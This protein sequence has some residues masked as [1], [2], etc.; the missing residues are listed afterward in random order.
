MR[1]LVE[2][3]LLLLRIMF[4]RGQRPPGVDNTLSQLRFEIEAADLDRQGR[5][6]GATPKF[7]GQTGHRLH[8]GCGGFPKEGWVNADLAPEADLLLDLRLPSPLPDESCSLIYSEHF[9]EHI[10]Y[11]GNAR[12]LLADYFRLL[13]PGGKVS[14]SVPDGEMALHAYSKGEEEFF[15]IT[16]ERWHP[17]WAETRMAQI[18]FMWRQDGE[19]LFIYDEETFVAELER[20]GF[21]NARRRDFDPE[22]DREERRWGSLFVEG[23]KPKS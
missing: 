3:L 13:E 11:P 16:R 4:R 17:K 7:S 9:F 2:A 19:H 22:L 6:R 20:A 15:R 18:N 5:A 14:F 21:V 8:L 12:E 1:T 23:T 10:A